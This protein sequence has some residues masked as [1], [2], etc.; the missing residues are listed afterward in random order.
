MERIKLQEFMTR[1]GFTQQQLAEVIGVK[2]ELVG[3]W[4]TGRSDL[5]RENMSKLLEAGMYLDE[6]FGDEVAGKITYR[7]QVDSDAS[8]NPRDVVISGL[9]AIIAE[10]E[11]K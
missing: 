10:L 8:E 2:R 1:K 5:T 11:R 4:N 7:N 3:A 9:K 6:I